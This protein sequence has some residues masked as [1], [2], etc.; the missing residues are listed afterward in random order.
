M[1]FR[2]AAACMRSYVL[3]GM[4]GRRVVLRASVYETYADLKLKIAPVLCIPPVYIHFVVNT[5]VVGDGERL[6][7]PVADGE[8]SYVVVG[9]V[10]LPDDND[11]VE[12]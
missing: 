5:R 9:P 12:P 8:L 7:E 1:L 2:G 11:G 10:P 4:D 3:R 6:G